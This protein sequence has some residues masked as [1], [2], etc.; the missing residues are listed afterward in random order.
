VTISIG[1]TAALSG[2]PASS[3][4]KTLSLDSGGHGLALMVAAAVLDAHAASLT[5]T[6]ESVVVTL[7][8]RGPS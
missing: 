3:G 2:A 6:A 8:L 1:P 7:P 4:G 5:T